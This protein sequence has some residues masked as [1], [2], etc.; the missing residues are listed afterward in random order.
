MKF[1]D[2]TLSHGGL[3]HRTEA[4]VRSRT[5]ATSDWEKFVQGLEIDEVND[6]GKAAAFIRDH[7]LDPFF[8][9]AEVHIG[10]LHDSIELPLDARR[11]LIKR[12]KQIQA[13]LQHARESLRKFDNGSNGKNF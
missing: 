13:L 7:I 11:V 4:A 1:S 6:T 8:Q 3:C 5:L 12:W 10:F 9:E 2:Y